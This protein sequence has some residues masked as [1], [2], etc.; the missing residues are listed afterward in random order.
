MASA[1]DY[2]EAAVLD[3]TFNLA[4]FTPAASLYVA[5]FTA[6]PSDSGGGTEVSGNAY[7]RVE[8]TNDNT[9]WSRSSST[10]SNDIAIT[11]AAPSPSNWG[12]VT[13]WG[14]FDAASAGNLYFH[15]ALTNSRS[16]TVGV[17]LSFDVAALTVTAA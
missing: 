3:H 12:T 15:A 17:A 5:L 10:V 11:F 8:V 16:T 2:L 1:S 13:H 9:T 6:A 14:I 4:T 7:A